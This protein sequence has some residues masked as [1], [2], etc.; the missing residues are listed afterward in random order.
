[1]KALLERLRSSQAWQD[2]LQTRQPSSSSLSSSSTNAVSLG[3][4]PSSGSASSASETRDDVE[5]LQRDAR[6][7]RDASGR[8]EDPKYDAPVSSSSSLLS[9]SLNIGSTSDSVTSA[10]STVPTSAPPGPSVASLLS[11]LQ[12]YIPSS[13]GPVP[14]INSNTNS[15]SGITPYRQPNLSASAF[16]HNTRST[17]F[18]HKPGSL[19]PNFTA[20]SSSSPFLT[21]TPQLLPSNLASSDNVPRPDVRNYT[22]Q[23]ALPVVAQ[24]A[25]DPKFIEAIAAVRTTELFS[26]TPV[27]IR[28]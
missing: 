13:I 9:A 8:S 5:V 24:L 19:T 28:S 14:D 26:S 12:A 17:G 23:Q 1:M 25:G 11:Q 10:S 15:N 20:S 3:S 22:F 2:T 4:D 21:H 7:T 6:E 16:P 27:L 18:D